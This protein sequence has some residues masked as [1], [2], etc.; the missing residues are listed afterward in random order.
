MSASEYNALASAILTFYP[1]LRFTPFSPIYVSSPFG[2]TCK[3]YSK[4]EY[5]IH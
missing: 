3:S 2:K 5:L 1:P 4:Q